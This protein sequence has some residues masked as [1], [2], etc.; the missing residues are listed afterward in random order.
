MTNGN[1]DNEKFEAFVTSVGF[2]SVTIRERKSKKVVFVLPY[3]W[4]GGVWVSNKEK[5]ETVKKE[6]GICL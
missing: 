2:P 1:A 4:A 3:S 5:R 6:Y